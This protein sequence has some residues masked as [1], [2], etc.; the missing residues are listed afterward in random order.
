MVA[1][2]DT[3][4]QQ[5]DRSLD[6]TLRPKSWDE[7]IGQELIKKNLKILIQAA[8]ERGEPIEHLLFYGPPGL[9]KTTLAHLISRELKAQVKVTSGPAIEKVG[10][11]ASILT[12]LSAGDILFID[13]AHRLNKLIEEILYPA[14]ES[15]SLDIIIGKGPSARTI[16]L[17]LPPFTLIAAT[18]RIALLSSPL[19]SRFSG[20]TYRLD[21]YTEDEIKKIIARSAKILGINIDEGA[22]IEIAKR[23][24]FTP[25]VANRLLKRCRDFSQVEKSNSITG[26]LALMALDLLEIDPVGLESTDRMILE[27]IISKFGG[28]PVGL[29]TLAA[30]TSEEKETIEEVYEPYLMRSGFVE[31]TPRGRIAT[32]RAYE[33]LGRNFTGQS[34]FLS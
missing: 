4:F 32:R 23:S 24:R 26:E 13:E 29:Q 14:L 6:Q 12:N 21:F 15:R 16:Q 28:G 8:Q 2:T 20:G 7:Y 22:T 30:A 17:E 1:I 27:T 33:H 18:T 10:D 34:T 9:G 31:R 3:K 25:R 11:L 5:D 19:R